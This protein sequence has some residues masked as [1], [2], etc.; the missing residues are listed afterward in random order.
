MCPPSSTTASSTLCLH[1]PGSAPVPVASVDET[2]PASTPGLVLSLLMLAAKAGKHM[3]VM[4]W[5][6]LRVPASA[7]ASSLGLC[8]VHGSDFAV[9]DC[10]CEE[11]CARVYICTRAF[12]CAAI[13]TA[14]VPC[15]PSMPACV[16]VSV[17]VSAFEHMRYL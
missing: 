15:G 7:S 2:M 9:W 5:V 12:M 13:V 17:S 16:S 10:A 1:A 6:A 8:V 3:S 4:P 11:T 14:T